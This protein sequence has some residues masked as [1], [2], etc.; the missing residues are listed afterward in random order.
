MKLPDEYDDTPPPPPWW[1]GPVVTLVFVFLLILFCEKCHSREVVISWDTPPAVEQVVGWR[2]WEDTTL[3]QASSIPT[4]ILTID[5]N[6]ITVTVTAI[7]AAGESPHS[8]PL[9]IPL[10]SAIVQR[11]KDLVVWT[12]LMAIPAQN[13]PQLRVRITSPTTVTL[14]QFY[15]AAPDWQTITNLPYDPPEFFRLQLP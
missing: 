4:A 13:H 3:I 2:V 10:L 11:S 7:N 8:D 5:N 12:N 15:D 1:Q 14:E 6:P 9:T